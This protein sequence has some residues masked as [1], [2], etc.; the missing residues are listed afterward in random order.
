MKYIQPL[1]DI[2][3]ETVRARGVPN[4]ECIVLRTLSIVD[5]GSLALLIGYRD[6]VGNVQALRNYM[7]WFGDNLMVPGTLINIYTGGGEA[8]AWPTGNGSYVH[9]VF[10]GLENTIFTIPELLPVLTRIQQAT[11]G[12]TPHSGYSPALPQSPA[13]PKLMHRALPMPTISGKK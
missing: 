10:W 4:Q 11:V 6:S 7:F 12:E 13:S 5:T 2:V 9:N 1:P 8:N 3:I